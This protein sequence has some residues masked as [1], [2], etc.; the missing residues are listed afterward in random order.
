MMMISWFTFVLLSFASFRLTRLVVYDKITAFLRA[1]F[2]EREIVSLEDG[3][4]EEQITIKGKGI[5]Y[6]IG[7]LLSCYWCVGIW[8]AAILCVGLYF[9]NPIFMP[10]VIILAVAGVAAIIETIVSYFL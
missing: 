7:S 4:M 3:S 6:G 10:I 8:T 9:F 2:L 5:R 1:P